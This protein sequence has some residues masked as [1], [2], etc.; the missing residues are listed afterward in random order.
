[1]KKSWNQR[2][3]M[4]M[5]TDFYEL[6]MSQGYFDSGLKDTQACYDL[7]FRQVPEGGGFAIM[8]GVEQ[9]MDYLENLSFTDDDVD[10]LRSTANFSEEFLTYLRN[11]KFECDV[12]AIPEGTPLFPNEPIVKVRGPIIQAQ[13]IETMLLLTIN[14]QS[15]IATKASRIVRAGQG[16]AIM[17]F[18]ARRAQGTD[19]SVLGARAA[20]IGG[21]HGTSC[22]ICGEQFGIPLSGTM[23]HSFVQAFPTEYEAFVAYAKSWPDQAVFLVDTYN[24]LNSGIPNT[25]RV[26][27]EILEPRG[28]R[29]KGIRIDSGDLTWLTKE[30]RAML[31]AAGMEDCRII[32]SNALDEYLIS[33]LINQGAIFDSCGVGE[34]LIT[35]RSEPV[36][37]GVYKLAGIEVD[38][39]M[40]PRMKVS[41]NLAK[42]T[43][44]GSKEVWRFFDNETGMAIAD[45]ITLDDEVIDTSESYELFDPIHTWKRKTVTN[46]TARKLLQPIFEKGRCVYP[47]Y[48]VQDIRRYCAEQQETLWDSVKRFNNPQTYYVDLSLKL[49]EIRNALLHRYGVPNNQ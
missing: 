36:F 37:G 4:T 46:F 13:M 43:T 41:E 45:L 18:G 28:K 20:Y 23:A 34:R 33:D 31:D 12:W 7:Y 39:R 25:I 5:L 8:A 1:M 38:G 14:H 49:W 35:S 17:E 3:N 30:S 22:T 29:V 19:A 44:P 16:R 6:T 15:L 48:N 40:E 24:V 2:T 9:M 21:A 32:V 10:Y 26:S 47:R 42:I 27:R 11:L